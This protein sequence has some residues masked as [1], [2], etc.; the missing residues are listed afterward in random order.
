LDKDYRRIGKDDNNNYCVYNEMLKYNATY[1][2]AK[3]NGQYSNLMRFLR[4]QRSIF[5]N[6]LLSSN[7]SFQVIDYNDN[8]DTYLKSSNIETT[9]KNTV[10][11]IILKYFERGTDKAEKKNA[12]RAEFFKN[13]VDAKTGKL[14][15]AK[16]RDGK[17][18]IGIGDNYKGELVE[19]N[20]FLN[21][22]FYIEGLMSNNLRMSLTGS[23]INHPDKAKNTPLD[24][25]K[26]LK[27]NSPDDVKALANDLGIVDLP[28]DV[29]ANLKDFFNGVN[30]RIK[31]NT[32]HDLDLKTNIPNNI[33]WYV[34]AIKSK[35]ME[36]IINTAQ[37]TQF[38]R[39]VIIPATLQYCRQNVFNGILP[40]LKCAVI[41]DD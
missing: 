14:I 26:K 16:T 31:V 11:N 23:E 32:I 5:V 4:N 15:I 3:T 2:Y 29:A 20:P 8:Y 19:L 10:L 7:S 17:N 30:D 24:V 37:G 6:N 13:W 36:R 18:I 33:S 9:S 28:M 1:L 40:R 38:K 25:I 12:R 27:V 39:N 41:R 35:T 22:F 34:E 21:K